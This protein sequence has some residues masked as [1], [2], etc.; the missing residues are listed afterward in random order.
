[1]IADAI[2][3]TVNG[4]FES[5]F[6][7]IWIGTLQMLRSVLG[8]VGKLGQVDPRPGGAAISGALWSVML[9]L[10]LLIAVALFFAQLIMAFLNPRR[11]MLSAVTGPVQY[12]VATAITVG[13]VLALLGSANG[14]TSVILQQGAGVTNVAAQLDRMGITDQPNAVQAVVLGVLGMV[15][16]LPLAIGY[17]VMMLFRSATILVLIATLPIVS[18]GLVNFATRHWFWRATRWLLALIFLQP[19]FALV[20][21]LGTGIVSTAGGGAPQIPNQPAPAD[22][23][24]TGVVTLLLGLAILFVALFAPM[25]LFR[26]FAFVEPGT[27]PHQTMMSAFSSA[28]DGFKQ[29]GSGIA[30][31]DIGAVFSGATSGRFGASGG[32]SSGEDG[33]GGD[34]GDDKKKQAAV[35]AGL[36]VA[37]G[38]ASAADRKSVV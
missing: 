21:T 27:M 2:R 20:F 23:S 37:T 28:V 10:A 3:D 18:A 33:S 7:S 5:L 38:G 31:A 14:L 6:R 16:V 30:N 1:M 17:G 34:G 35:A 9:Q 24:H 22:G 32:D 29:A 15:A 8:L 11:H 25:A 36:A 4:L 26:L 12:G 19:T 13:I